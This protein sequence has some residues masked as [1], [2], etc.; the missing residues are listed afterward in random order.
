VTL[1]LVEDG[2][3]PAE[4]TAP[5]IKPVHVG[6]ICPAGSTERDYGHVIMTRKGASRH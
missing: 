6:W 1:C 3:D 4:A 5:D 2:E